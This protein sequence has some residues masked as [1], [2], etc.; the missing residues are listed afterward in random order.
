MTTDSTHLYIGVGGEVIGFPGSMS[1]EGIGK[2]YRTI[3]G[4]TFELI[5]NT[6]GTGI[7][8]LY[9]GPA[10]SVTPPPIYTLTISA[11]SGGTTNPSPGTYQFTEGSTVRIEAIADSFHLFGHWE[12]NGTNIGLTNP[13]NLTLDANYAVHAVF[14]LALYDVTIQAYCYNE[15]DH[16]S[17]N[18]SM[19]GGPAVFE[20]PHTFR[21]LRGTHTF[22]VSDVNPHGH[23]FYGWF[24]WSPSNLTTA[25]ISY[26][27]TYTAYYGTPQP[28]LVYVEDIISRP[29][30]ISTTDICIK[31]VSDLFAWTAKLSWEPTH[32]NLVSYEEGPFLRQGGATYFVDKSGGNSVS[33]ASTLLGYLPG[34]PSEFS[35]S[36]PASGV[37]A[38]ITLCAVAPVEGAILNLSDVELLNSHLWHIETSVQDGES[39]SARCYDIEPQFGVVD[40]VDLSAVG[41]NYARNVTRLTRTPTSWLN[42][43][44]EGWEN[45]YYVTT[46]DDLRAVCRIDGEATMWKDFMFNTTGWSGVEKVEVGL[47]TWIDTGTCNIVTALSN[48]NGTSFSATTFTHAVDNAKYDKFTWIDVT[49]AY[50]WTVADIR[51]ITVKLTYQYVAGANV[52]VDYLVVAVTPQPVL[53]PP[54]VFDSDADVNYDRVVDID[55]LALVTVNYGPYGPVAPMQFAPASSP[56]TSRPTN[57]SFT[58][59]PPAVI[60]SVPLNAYDGSNTTQAIWRYTRGSATYG[61][62][63]GYFELTAYGPSAGTPRGAIITQVD[64]AVYFL[65]SQ[66][67]GEYGPRCA[68]IIRAL[69]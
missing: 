27:G 47:E 23:S 3:D 20:T 38:T 46:S 25:T 10:I 55:D 17:V 22:T 58:P 37:L 33:M 28:P 56:Y 41:V 5:S 32:F 45:P 43:T 31:G 1:G 26:E 59:P 34:Y 52:R 35:C 54:N 44:S 13:M 50:S 4:S 49:G 21:G 19:D 64:L 62:E 9:Y 29:G 14:G 48:D 36:P 30:G 63:D 68:Q 51:S 57:F 65:A 7:Q 60:V 12:L 6:L 69:D 11:T 40:V 42:V 39:H 61:T 24:R 2:V 53:S 66:P 8:T 15:R 16:V 67:Y 18:I